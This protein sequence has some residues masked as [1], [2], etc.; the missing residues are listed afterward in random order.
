[1]PLILQPQNYDRWLHGDDSVQPRVDLL[2]PYDVDLM[3]SWKA[4]P[5]VGNML[6]NMPELSEVKGQ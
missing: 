5:R 2:P 6:N 4:D 1:M 3:K